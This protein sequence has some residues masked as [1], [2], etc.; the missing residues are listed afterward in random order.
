MFH[1]GKNKKGNWKEEVIGWK[2]NEFGSRHFKLETFTEHFSGNELN[3]EFMP[4][5]Q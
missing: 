4:K 2:E 1:E 3:W 5:I